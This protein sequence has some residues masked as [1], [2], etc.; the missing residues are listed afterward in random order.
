M[1]REA[2]LR[3]DRTAPGNDAGHPARGERHEGQAHSGV[4]G[5][6]VHALLGLLDE[7]VP[8]QLPG[9]VLGHPAHLLERLIDRDGADR[10]RAV[11]DDPLARLVDV[12]SGRE[13]HHRVRA[14]ARRPRHLLDLFP[15]ARRHR[16]IADVRVD[17]HQEIAADDHRLGFR[18]VDVRRDDRPP[19]RHLVAHELG[20]HLL[21]KVRSES[22]ARMA[23]SP[24]FLPVRFA[25]AV[26][27]NHDELHLGGDDTLPRV[28]HL[29]D[30]GAGSGPTRRP[31]MS[32][33]QR[34]D[35]RVVLTQPAIFGRHGFEAFGIAPLLDPPCPQR[36]QTLSD[37]DLRI[38]VRIRAGG[39][40]HE[41][42]IIA[43]DALRRTGLGERDLSER[44]VQVRAAAAPIHL[45][46]TRKR[47]H[48][49]RID[50]GRLAEKLLG[51]CAHG[52]NL[53]GICGGA[54]V[55]SGSDCGSRLNPMP[56]C[57]PPK[58]SN[59]PG[60]FKKC[61]AC[62]GDWLDC[63]FK[64]HSGRHFDTLCRTLSTGGNY[65]CRA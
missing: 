61:A 20:R 12:L 36:R 7:G 32:E 48:R 41:D 16:G 30:V 59:R 63:R 57:N 53:I 64:H 54:P 47:L 65:G 13:I 25:H 35:L 31:Q 55:A 9:E 24:H 26:L 2:P 42:G 45:P 18:V 5:E 23:K 49:L 37:I 27:A 43:L 28:V 39:V 46:R 33:A 15:D 14:P 62:G 10:H 56:P 6:I 52:G 38:R 11:A 44:H 58:L 50:S 1:V 19:R 40:V 60:V 34:L 21:R 8:V 4:D 3:H 29:R 17:L 22:H 51:C